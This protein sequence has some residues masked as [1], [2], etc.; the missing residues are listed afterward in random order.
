MHYMYQLTTGSIATQYGSNSN[1][2]FGLN[3]KLVNNFTF[4]AEG[5]FMFASKYNDV[6]D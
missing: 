6:S 5:Q 3:I 2:G 4:G 1:A